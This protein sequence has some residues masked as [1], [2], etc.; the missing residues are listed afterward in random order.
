MDAT[1]KLK[2]GNAHYVLKAQNS[3]TNLRVSAKDHCR[4]YVTFSG[5]IVPKL[6]NFLKTQGKMQKSLIVPA[7]TL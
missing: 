6:K 4:K 3:I 1:K 2:D 5:N 7:N